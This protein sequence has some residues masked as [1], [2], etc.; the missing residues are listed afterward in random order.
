MGNVER[1]LI[2]RRITDA[3]GC[4]TIQRESIPGEMG[5]SAPA[6]VPAQ[7]VIDAVQRLIPGAIVGVT[8]AD[9]L[10]LNMGRKEG[11]G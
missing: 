10:P 1:V 5:L 7:L 9:M 8:L 11:H 3:G 6:D 2:R 4:W